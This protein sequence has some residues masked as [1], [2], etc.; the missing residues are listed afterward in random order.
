[1][2]PDSDQSTTPKSEPDTDR[3]PAAAATLIRATR[4]FGWVVLPAGGAWAVAGLTAGSVNVMLLGLLA[5]VFG[6]FLLFEASSAPARPVAGLATRL[7]LAT[8]ITAVGV[9]IVEPIVG[10]AIAIGSLIPVVLALPYVDR[11]TLNR[12]MA[13]SMAVGVVALAAR[14]VIPWGDPATEGSAV[15]LPTSALVIVYSLFVLFLR[16]ASSRLADTASE[17]RAVVEMSRDLSSTLDPQDVGN[18]LAHHIALA[19]GADEGAISTWDRDGDRVVTFGYY[20]PEH[21]EQLEPDFALD[22]YPATRAVLLTQRPCVIDVNDPDADRAEV[23]YLRSV[24]QRSMI[25][26]PLVARGESIGIV[27]LGS[28]RSRA[29]G[30]RQ[31]ELAQLLVREAAVTFDNARLYE[32]LRQQAYRDALTGLANRARFHERVDH[33]LERL[34]GRSPL[35]LAVLFIDLDQFK[36]INDRF[37]HT[38]GDRALHVIADRIRATVRPGDTP[39]R[40]GGD[41]FAVLLEDVEG[42]DTANAVSQRLLDVLAEPVELE[43]GEAIVGAS[44]GIAISGPAADTTD[45]LLRNADIAMYAA[46]AA[47][48]GQMVHFRPDLLQLASARGELAAMLRGAA[49]RDELQ[50]HFQPIVRLEDGT[51][52]AVEALVRWQPKGDV[53]HMPAEFM[54]LAEETGEIV[55]IGR[56]VIAE[57]CR[58]ARSWQVR[59]RRPD[60]RLHVNLSARQFRDPGLVPLINAALAESG[61]AP[62][63]LTLEIIEST[64]L[65]HAEETRGRIAELRRLGVRIAIDDFGTGYSALNSLHAF[66]VDELK[67]D[68]SFVPLEDRDDARVLSEAIVEVGRGLGLEMIAEGIETDAQAAWFRGLGCRLGQG[69]RYA[70]PMPAADLERYLR[71][72]QRSSGPTERPEPQ[73]QPSRRNTSVA[74]PASAT[75][76]PTTT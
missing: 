71:R 58:L 74:A 21:I 26:L 15:L 72:A 51:P 3:E 46:K 34:R 1:M 75:V 6:A 40:L 68:R 53:L 55:S 59:F 7:A 69:Y 17:L 32:S 20:P 47:G 5:L 65:T 54:T 14:R 28:S 50:L 36:L 44:I 22:R 61:L 23:G 12:L 45:V 33:A 63:A 57:A 25:M 56:W 4:W 18:R 73:R 31:V 35:H 49:T 8:L 19:A 16:N 39:A 41:E 9:V 38:V 52:T 29:F 67:V 27:E 24:G 13:G 30:Q 62:T 43:S 2:P 76:R 42:L 11:S 60:L 70:R 64:L 37:G 10:P 66:E 48:R